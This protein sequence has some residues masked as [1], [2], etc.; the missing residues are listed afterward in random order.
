MKPT[1]RDVARLAGVS[2]S[3]VSYALSG[4]RPISAATRQRIAAAIAQLTFYPNA[5]A[6]ALAGQ[7][8]FVIAVI[9][10]LTSTSTRSGL[11]P[12]LRA[13]TTDLRDHDYDVLLVTADEGV[14]GLRRV[15]GRRI[16]DAVIVM[17]VEAHD[18][19][20]AAA[21]DLD[22][23]VV[24]IGLPREQVHLPCVDFDFTAA[25]Q[26][27]VA[28]LADFGC[29]AV[30]VLGYSARSLRRELSYVHRLEQGAR[31]E[32]TR[33]SLR[34]ELIQPFEAGFWHARAAVAD[35]LAANVDTGPPCARAGILVA[36]SEA[37]ADVVRALRH[38]GLQPGRDVP[39]VALCDG[40]EAVVDGVAVPHIPLEPGEV[41]RR[42]VART[43]NM[44]VDSV[45][46]TVGPELVPPRLISGPP[47][48]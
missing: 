26:L 39:F 17:E 25:G 6:R 44:I 28:A 3:T 12:F 4:K 36:H 34:L 30:T 29:R 42:A 9:A 33:R 13:I 8:T 22:V 18:A 43:L 20:L 14:E 2:Q 32:A 16:V 35:A 24:F 45:S 40:P 7:R 15:V 10:P 48:S 5:G 21:H 47:A 31:A 1:S 46:G 11:L 27:A 38:Q 41:S 37:V 19:R 23:P